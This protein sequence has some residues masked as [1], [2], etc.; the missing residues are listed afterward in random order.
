M[1]LSL[2]ALS[3]AASGIVRAFAMAFC[4]SA[5]A[6]S[7]SFNTV[8]FKAN[9][10]SLSSNAF[11]RA[12]SSVLRCRSAAES[13]FWQEQIIAKEMSIERVKSFFISGVNCN[14][15]SVIRNKQTEGQRLVKR[16]LT[17][18][19][20]WRSC[21]PT[22]RIPASTRQVAAASLCR[23]VQPHWRPA[24]RHSAVATACHKENS[25][26]AVSRGGCFLEL[27]PGDVDFS[28]TLPVTVL[29]ILYH[30]GRRLHHFNLGAHFVDLGGLLFD[31]GCESHY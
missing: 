14:W 5:S 15:S 18:L 2:S 12:S 22:V 31:L 24:R 17:C 20:R 21:F 1:L 3:C 13:C 23:G 28:T 25:R 26:R 7:L 9:S 30:P 4:F 19:R 27:Y 8:S 16:N 29:S 10:F 11:W 6:R